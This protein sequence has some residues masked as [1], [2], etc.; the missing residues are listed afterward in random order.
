[1]HVKCKTV[2]IMQ[3]IAV[4]HSYAND[5]VRVPPHHFSH[6]ALLFS[7]ILPSLVFHYV[8]SASAFRLL[9][10]DTGG[11]SALD[12]IKNLSRCFGYF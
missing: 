3:V 6:V 12:H 10:P 11:D 5:V 4:L 7:S 2:S 9:I 1:M 8:V